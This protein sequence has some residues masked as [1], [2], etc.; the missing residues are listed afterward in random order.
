MIWDEAYD[1][2]VGGDGDNDWFTI[3][4]HN[5]GWYWQRSVDWWMIMGV[6]KL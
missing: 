5:Y 3:T 6:F 4:E 2:D 1:R